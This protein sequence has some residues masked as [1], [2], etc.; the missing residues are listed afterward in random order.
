MQELVAPTYIFKGFLKIA[1]T[2]CLP[3]RKKIK[4]YL[5]ALHAHKSISLR[6]REY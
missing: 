4:D 1:E 6:I 3:Y 5:I 2:I